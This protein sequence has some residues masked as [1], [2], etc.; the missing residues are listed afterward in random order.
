MKT[1][2]AYFLLA[3]ILYAAPCSAFELTSPDFTDSA[4]LP[5]RSSCDST[6]T[7]PGLVW[8]SAP[9]GTKSFALTCIDPDAPKGDFIH[10]IVF[11][12]PASATAIPPGGRLPEGSSELANDYGRPGFGP[13]CPPAGTH[14][15]VFT[16]YALNEDRL[17]SVSRDDFFKAVKKA[18][19]GTATLTGLYTRK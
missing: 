8:S 6:G 14:R 5:S 19:I 7:A 13:A 11:D 9:S 4:Q 3:G 1:A 18:R 17:G 10:W 12:I 16:L 2:V 15:Y